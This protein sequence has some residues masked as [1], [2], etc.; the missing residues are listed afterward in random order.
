MRRFGIALFVVGCHSAAPKA[1]NPDASIAATKDAAVD[2]ANPPTTCARETTLP[3]AALDAYDIAS[4]GTT[5]YLSVKATNGAF[6][7]QTMPLAGGPTTTLV[8]SP[9]G[10]FRLSALGNTIFYAAELSTGFT[11]E[12]HQV[13]GATDTK[14]GEVMSNVPVR[15]SATATDVYVATAVSPDQS[16][17]WRLSRAGGTPQALSTVTVPFASVNAVVIGTTKVAWLAAGIH[18]ADLPTPNA[19][20]TASTIGGIGFVGDAGFISSSRPYGSSHSH[21]FTISHFTPDEA[22]VAETLYT[23]GDAGGLFTDG[24]RFYY[25]ISHWHPDGSGMTYDLVSF[26]ADGTNGRLECNAE[27]GARGQQDATNIYGLLQDGA[28]GWH[29]TVLAKL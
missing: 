9:V 8:T 29:V 19:G 17:L 13:T 27:L 23:F 14:L 22:T 25:T 24:T 21:M 7:L 18:V 16:I 11:F 10:A 26:D 20:P 28:T 1:D 4:D 6:E 3:F 5:L 15:L 12:V 2:A